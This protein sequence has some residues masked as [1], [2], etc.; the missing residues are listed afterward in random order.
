MPFLAFP[1][2]IPSHHARHAALQ[3]PCVSLLAFDALSRRLALALARP[4][5]G[6]AKKTTARFTN[7]TKLSQAQEYV[8]NGRK[9]RVVAAEKCIADLLQEYAYTQGVTKPILQLAP[10]ALDI[11]LQTFWIDLKK[12]DETDYPVTTLKTHRSS[13]NRYLRSHNYGATEDEA[14]P[15]LCDSYVF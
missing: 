8:Q 5:A 14:G 11:L 15:D 9:K 4:P 13:L 6:R 2:P 7:V 12:V 3:L 10:K 1:A